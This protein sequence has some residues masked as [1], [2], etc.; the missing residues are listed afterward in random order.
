MWIQLKVARTIDSNGWSKK[1]GAGSIVNVGK[2]M[3][4]TMIAEGAAVAI[5]EDAMPRPIATTPPVAVNW[6]TPGELLTLFTIPREFD[7]GGAHVARQLNAIGSWAALT[8]RPHTLLMCDDGGVARTARDFGCG[9]VQYLNRSAHGVPYL[10]SAFRHAVDNARFDVICYANSDVMFTDTLM[11]A[12]QLA[13]KAFPA[14]VMVGRRRQMKLDGKFG[15]GRGWQERL[16]KL[17]PALDD[18]S[19]MDYFVFTRGAYRSIGMLNFLVGSPAWDNWLLAEAIR[20]D[21]PTID[22][23]DAIFCAHHEHERK[24]PRFGIDHNR[25]LAHGVSA[26]TTDTRYVLRASGEIVERQK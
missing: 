22:A 17:A 15:F 24:W 2:Q 9:Y 25:T 26:I 7:S 23:S 10:S 18:P 4:L 5:Y 21:I 19:A 6:D 3:A 14:F 16:K 13:A 20:A 11:E 1:F 12:A 8:P